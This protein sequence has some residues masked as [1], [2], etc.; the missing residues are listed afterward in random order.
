MSGICILNAHTE[1]KLHVRP[2]HSA[3]ILRCKPVTPGLKKVLPSI[4]QLLDRE[5]M[6]EDVRNEV[7][8]DFAPSHGFHRV[9]PN[10]RSTFQSFRGGS[11]RSR[12]CFL[13]GVM[14]LT[15]QCYLKVQSKEHSFLENS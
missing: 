10:I 7:V 11:H 2:S 13:T 4:F 1:Q 5:E 6:A 9:A 15:I 12:C 14:H 3:R 8:I